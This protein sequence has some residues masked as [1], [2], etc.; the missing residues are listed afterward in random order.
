[1]HYS[2]IYLLAVSLKTK[3]FIDDSLLSSRQQTLTGE[4]LSK[5]KDELIV[6]SKRLTEDDSNRFFT[7]IKAL[8]DMYDK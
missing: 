5:K 4:V 1:M 2:S 8:A 6:Q 7:Q 3:K